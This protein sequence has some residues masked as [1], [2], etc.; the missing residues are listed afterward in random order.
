VCRYR[1]D[2]IQR[3]V[4]TLSVYDVDSQIPFDLLF[5]HTVDVLVDD[6]RRIHVFLPVERNEQL[7]K[8]ITVFL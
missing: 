1:I 8:L 2:V 5:V 3:I 6:V 7:E 4:R